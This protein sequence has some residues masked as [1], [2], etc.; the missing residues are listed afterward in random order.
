MR[1]K[2]VVCRAGLDLLFRATGPVL[3]QRVGRCGT[4]RSGGRGRGT[5]DGSEG[6]A[7]AQARLTGASLDVL[8]TR[9][10]GTR[11]L[12]K[13][14]PKLHSVPSKG[15]RDDNGYGRVGKISLQNL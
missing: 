5:D 7:A 2:S 8:M 10:C 14:A 3:R 13:P 6:S 11:T 4:D 15:W 12:T 1:D 9:E